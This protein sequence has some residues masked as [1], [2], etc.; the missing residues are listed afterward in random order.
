MY[1]KEIYLYVRTV[2]RY[3]CSDDIYPYKVLTVNILEIFK[4]SGFN[5]CSEN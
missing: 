5:F 1:K 3:Y 2:N 4:S